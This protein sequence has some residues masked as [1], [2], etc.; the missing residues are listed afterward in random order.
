M[1]ILLISE[2]FPTSVDG[3]FTGGV[4]ARTFF[5]AREL[6]RKHDII[7][8]C[9]DTGGKRYEKMMGFTIF[10]V[11]PK[12]VHTS[13]FD[14]TRLL[15]ILS[16]I[17]KGKTVRS[18]IVEGTNFINQLIAYC[19]GKLQKT[20]IVAWTPDVWRGQWRKNMGFVGG[21]I[22]NLIESFNLCHRDINYIA[23]SKTVA[24]KMYAV[25]VP[26][27]LITVIPCGVD[28]K[29]I[30]KIGVKKYRKPVVSI[31]CRLVKYKNVDILIRAFGLLAQKNKACT[32]QIVGQ[33]PEKNNLERL[34]QELNIA[35]RT[36]FVGFIP[37]H[38]D[39][40]KKLSKSYL[41]CLPSETEGFGIVTVE[42]MAMGLPVVLA[43]IAINREVTEEKGVLFFKPSNY[44]D[45][46][47]K[48][49]L[50]MTNHKHYAS[51]SKAAR[52]QARKYDWVDIAKKTEAFYA[53]LCAY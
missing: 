7:V 30:Q 41:F 2:F 32:L 45:L 35:N 47:Q 10:R 5:I 21:V 39:V 12:R 40:L 17:W 48:L 38:R 29:E 52:Q 28:Y 27:K 13:G 18:D 9:S 25:G 19:I 14:V 53:S 24:K 4:E 42:A 33:G 34:T 50:L 15:Y 23:I 31:V 37:K 49:S 46:F 20:P 51:L 8:I 1:R 11:G 16:A 43:D 26:K 22:G 44:H 3:D 36:R 6:A